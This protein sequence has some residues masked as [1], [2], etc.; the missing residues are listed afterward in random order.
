MRFY[1][2]TNLICHPTSGASGGDIFRC[3]TKDIE[4]RR[5]KGLQSRPLDSGFLYGG[6]RGDVRTFLRVRIGAIYAIKSAAVPRS[7]YPWGALR[8][9]PC[10]SVLRPDGDASASPEEV[11]LGC[12]AKIAVVPTILLGTRSTQESGGSSACNR[13]A[14][15]K[16]E[17]PCFG[18]AKRNNSFRHAV[19]RA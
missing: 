11:P 3:T 1:G 10:L 17:A 9:F 16:E 18:A 8:L 7:K 19:G 6:M 15:C 13:A 5:A 14:C 2:F 4:E 12:G